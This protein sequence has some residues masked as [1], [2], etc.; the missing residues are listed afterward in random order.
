M[1]TKPLK[2]TDR[3]SLERLQNLL[4]KKRRHLQ[5]SAPGVLL[6]Q[7]NLSY[8]DEESI[9]VEADGLGGAVMRIIEGNYPTDFY[10]HEEKVFL[11]EAEA[12]RVASTWVAN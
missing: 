11:T 3:R 6:F 5:I 9:F 4:N 8:G 7:A 10:T 1:N 12:V 2:T